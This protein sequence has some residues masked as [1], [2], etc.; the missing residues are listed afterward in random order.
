MRTPESAKVESDAQP[1][2][3]HLEAPVTWLRRRTRAEGQPRQPLGSA[4]P[5][6]VAD[7]ARLTESLA[8]LPLGLLVE[9]EHGRQIVVNDRARHPCGDVQADALAG[10]ALAEVAAR[11]REGEA[12]VR[13]VEL[14]GVPPRIFECAA[15]PLRAGGVVATI[16]DRS[17]RHRL[18]AIRRDF[19]ANVNHELRTPIGALSVLAEAL[20]EEAEPSTVRRL[21]GRIA[22]EADRAT[23]LLGDLLDFSRVEDQAPSL[24]ERI[25]VS[26]L[27]LASADRVAALAERSRVNLRLPTNAE[28]ITVEGDRAQLV[29]AI[30]NLLDNA[31]K[32]SD[33]GSAV[34]VT[35]ASQDGR[36]ALAVRDS[37]V[38]IPAKDL[39]R[40][41][42]RFY[43]V[44]RA[45]DRKTGG[46]GLGL[47]IVR[48]V[49][50]NHRGEVTVD[51]QEGLGST[52]TFHLPA[53]ELPR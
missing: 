3:R 42:E 49:A 43:R 30:A 20:L 37:G 28:G 10:R 22:V 7:L 46:T 34:D 47:A 40:I 41:F 45:R 6:V 11:A 50:S 48:H 32:Y 9:D 51:S 8:V 35:V 1:S 25:P 29:S 13:T 5:V 38:G 2:R 17:E 27:L 52:F 15:A 24:P 18:D 36:V 19:V 26:D 44:D 23:R 14:R 31:I 4:P 33:A 39:D 12:A 16:V 53:S 21:A